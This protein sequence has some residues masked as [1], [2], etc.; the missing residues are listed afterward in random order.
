MVVARAGLRRDRAEA[1]AGDGRERKRVA[2]ADGGGKPEYDCGPS[3]TSS[4]APCRSKRG[5]ANL[6]RFR[7]L[8]P[9]VLGGRSTVGHGALDAVIGVRIPAS[10]PAFAHACPKT[11]VSYGSAGSGEGCLAEA[12]QPRRRTTRLPS[13]TAPQRRT[14][15]TAAEAGEPRLGR[16][17]RRLSNRN[18]CVRRPWSSENARFVDELGVAQNLLLPRSMGHR[19]TV[20]LRH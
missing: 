5:T 6:L 8:R 9:A 1:R 7:S 3:C 11:Y 16:L 10:Q 18:F 4:R 14:Q 19:Q 15:H 13:L 20:S 17:R 12:A 2:G